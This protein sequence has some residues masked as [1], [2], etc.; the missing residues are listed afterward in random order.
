MKVSRVPLPEH[1]G[2]TKYPWHKMKAKGDSFFVPA[3]NGKNA[4]MIQNSLNSIHRS[5]FKGIT[6]IVNEKGVQG[7]R[8]WRVK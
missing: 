1:Y 8:I 2:G 6:R 5:H 4:Y 7:V 3:D